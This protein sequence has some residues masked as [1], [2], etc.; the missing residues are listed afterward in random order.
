[1]SAQATGPAER[2]EPALEARRT[3]LTPG[4]FA[5]VEA[6]G[7]KRL[8]PRF[9]TVPLAHIDEDLVRAWLAAMAART[10]RDSMEER[11]SSSRAAPVAGASA[12]GSDR[13]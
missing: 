6:H 10:R 7:R 8:L 5:D 13:P 11:P 3:Y 9:G 4:S 2:D 12:G 1:M